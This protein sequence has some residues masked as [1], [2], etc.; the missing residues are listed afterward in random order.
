MRAAAVDLNVKSINLIVASMLRVK[1]NH[2]FSSKYEIKHTIL[3]I[4]DI[5]SEP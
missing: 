3:S 4:Q 2:I 1:R 5:Y